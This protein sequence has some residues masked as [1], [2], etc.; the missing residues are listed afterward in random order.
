MGKKFDYIMGLPELTD[1]VVK[2]YDQNYETGKYQLT[3]LREKHFVRCSS[4]LFGGL[5]EEIQTNKNC[6]YVT[7]INDLIKDGYIPEYL[8][9]LVKDGGNLEENMREVVSSR[10]L[11]YFEV[12]TTYET[13]ARGTGIH[14]VHYYVLSADFVSDQVEEFYTLDDLGIMVYNTPLEKIVADM[15]KKLNMYYVSHKMFHFGTV[16]RSQF[17]E[18]KQNIIGDFLYSYLVR[19]YVLDNRDIHGNNMGIMIRKDNLAMTFAPNYDFEKTLEY[20]SIIDD[21]DT[22]DNMK[23]VRFTYPEIFKKFKDKTNDFKN[24]K[25]SDGK[26]I[27]EDII[28]VTIGSE[29]FSQYM[30]DTC[31]YNLDKILNHCN[32]IVVQMPLP[33]EKY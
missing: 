33:E 14:A 23:Y 26:Y 10:I 21:T 20:I 16:D 6:S 18:M 17:E 8:S 19:R 27:F 25:T 28:D 7:H 15:N 3:G 1:D 4:G 30:K 29:Y 5:V 24:K 32:R 11:N 9:V 31:E 13:L 2:L 12:P 22:L